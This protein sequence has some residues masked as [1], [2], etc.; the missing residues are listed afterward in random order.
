MVK[1]YSSTD[2]GIA[3]YCY[4]VLYLKNINCIVLFIK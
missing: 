4:W 3:S 2:I 1:I